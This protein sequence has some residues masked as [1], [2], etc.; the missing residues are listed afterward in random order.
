MKRMASISHD[1]AL[2]AELQGDPYFV[3]EYLN[4]ALD[5]GFE[6]Q[7]FLVALR[8]VTRANGGIAK[9]AK[10]AGINRESLN[11]ALSARGDPPLTVLVAVIKAIGMKFTVVPDRT[12]ER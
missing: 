4:A 11:R 12:V 3:A 10:A 5:D 1:E 7:A 2:R 6:T 9:V 8:R